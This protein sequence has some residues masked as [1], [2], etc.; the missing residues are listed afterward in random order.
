MNLAALLLVYGVATLV[1]FIH[2]AEFLGDY[3]NMP[4][5]WTRAG[6]YFAWLGMTL[7]GVAGWLLLRRGFRLAG[8]ALLAAYAACG[9]DSLG[10]YVLAPVSAHTL[11]MNATI[12]LEVTA[13]AAL[14]LEV[15]RQFAQ[16]VLRGNP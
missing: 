5:T 12:L 15:A 3:P 4:A 7:V 2:N 11:A 8:L 10:H 1:H 9:L 14:L 16:R 13:A 6:V